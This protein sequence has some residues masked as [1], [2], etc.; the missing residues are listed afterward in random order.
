MRSNQPTKSWIAIAI[1]VSGFSAVA[2]AAPAADEE[3]PQADEGELRKGETEA[4]ILTDRVASTDSKV[5]G[6]DH[7][8]VRLVRS[9]EDGYFIVITGLRGRSEIVDIVVPKDK[10]FYLRSADESVALDVSPERA[11][12]IGADFQRLA[13]GLGATS[14]S[15]SVGARSVRPLG[16]SSVGGCVANTVGAVLAAVRTVLLAVDATIVCALGAIL[17]GSIELGVDGTLRQPAKFCTHTYKPTV[18]ARKASWRLMSK[19]PETCV[20]LPSGKK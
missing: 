17:S 18:A 20:G 19:M 16:A 10:D 4:A 12:A 5:S 14:A 8:R 6:V 11:K 9:D 1:L 15:G 3:A 13:E 7:W 2:C